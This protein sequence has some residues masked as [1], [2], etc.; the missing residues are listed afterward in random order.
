MSAGDEFTSRAEYVCVCARWPSVRDSE[1]AS[2]R[3]RKNERAGSA[4][5]PRACVC[6]SEVR[7]SGE[8]E[9]FYA[10]GKGERTRVSF[11]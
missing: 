7:D 3:E 5:D 10:R 4:P 9:H 1:G 11:I 8:E 6:L 2:H